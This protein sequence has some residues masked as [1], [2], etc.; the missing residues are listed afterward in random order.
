MIN[1]S[2]FGTNSIELEKFSYAVAE[3]IPAFTNTSDLLHVIE[4]SAGQGIIVVGSEIQLNDAVAFGE[5]VRSEYP[6]VKVLLSRKRID[7]DV[8][9]KALRAGFAEVITTE[10]TSGFVHSIRH[11]RE[12]INSA[13]SRHRNG[14]AEGVRKGRIVVV[15]SAKGG[16]GKTTLSINLATALSN[17]PNSRV[18]LVDLD[19]QF[20]DIAV[21]LQASP[22]K[23]ISAAIGM[24]ANLDL[25]GTRSII[26]NYDSNLDL[27]LAP[28]NPTDVEFIS[29]DLIGKVLDNL[30]SDYDY[31]VIDTPPAFTDFVLKSI[32][33]MDACYLITTLEMPAIKNLKIVLETLDALK[34]D[35]TLIRVVIN[36]A[37]SKTGITP[38]EAEV[39]LQRKV[40]YEL[41]NEASVAVAANQGQPLIR[42]A[43]KSQLGKVIVRMASELMNSLSPEL[44]RTP[45]TSKSL[46][47]RSKR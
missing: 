47:R 7:V 16:C 8:L 46:F 43:P 27:L 15:F 20:G 10:D 30:T 29:G 38:K 33:L 19:L 11:V 3:S 12:V 4:K 6:D 35:P 31:V 44:E 41:P 5:K 18:C 9:S 22:E 37:D 1:I 23:T 14:S 24:G 39:L 13:K 25:L 45:T 40:D 21:S 2:Y 42:F 32:E 36:R 17:T 26:T 28:T 34:V